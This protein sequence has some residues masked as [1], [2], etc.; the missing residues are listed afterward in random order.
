MNKSVSRDYQGDHRLLL[1]L[2]EDVI[3]QSEQTHKTH[4]TLPDRDCFIA[5]VFPATPLP[6]IG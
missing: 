1:A 3:N 4:G 2:A 5:N 6:F